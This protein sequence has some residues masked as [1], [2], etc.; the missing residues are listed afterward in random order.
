VI[1]L[2]EGRCK[3]WIEKKKVGKDLLLTLGG[4]EKPHIGGIVIC[5]PGKKANVLP[6]NGHCNHIILK[7]IAEHYCKK[8]G[9]RVVALGGVHINNASKEEI[10]KVIENCKE[11]IKRI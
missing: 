11:L 1:T 10:K 3:V 2:G 8:E 5:E 7:D 4:G 9:V 6:L